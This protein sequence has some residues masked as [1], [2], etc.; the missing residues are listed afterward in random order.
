[1]ARVFSFL[2]LAACVASAAA[3]CAEVKK[4][5]ARGVVD[6]GREDGVECGAKEG[7]QSSGSPAGGA[8]GLGNRPLNPL[9]SPPFLHTQTKWGENG[10]QE[11]VI[12][13]LY[14]VADNE[15]SRKGKD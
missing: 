12:K 14:D 8:C 7:R 1:M 15:V 9:S 13:F 6:G 11:N 4:T 3:G 2:L 5:N 10:K